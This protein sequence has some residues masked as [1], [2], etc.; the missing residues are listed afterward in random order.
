MVTVIDPR[1]Y[2]MRD[3][4]AAA[5]STAGALVIADLGIARG[6]LGHGGRIHECLASVESKHSKGFVR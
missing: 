1:N 3:E 4:G 2:V 6:P 5:D